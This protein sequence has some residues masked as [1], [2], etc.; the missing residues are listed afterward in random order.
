MESNPPLRTTSR[1]PT[2]SSAIRHRASLSRWFQGT[3]R[4]HISTNSWRAGCL[5][6]VAGLLLGQPLEVHTLKDALLILGGCGLVQQSP[7]PASPE[8]TG[9]SWPNSLDLWAFD[10]GV[11]FGH[12]ISSTTN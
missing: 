4:R 6:I 2:K 8:T 9:Y 10:G 7:V 12:P 3:G 1:R 5:G 11:S